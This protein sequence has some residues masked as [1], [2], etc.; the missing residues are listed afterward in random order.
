M[1][2]SSGVFDLRKIRMG[3]PYKVFCTTDTMHRVMHFIYEHTPVDYVMFSL[4]DSILV[5]R[6]EKQV[7]VQTKEASGVISSSLWNT[8]LDNELDPMLA[9]ELSEIYAWSIDFFGLQE[10]DGF[11]VFY[12]EHYV[13]SNY[14]GLG[15]I[16]GAVFYHATEEFYAMPFVQDSIESFYDQEGN[17][18]RK[19]FLKAPLRYS[20]ISSR[21]SH[22]RFHPI[23]KYRRPH[24]GVDYAAP[25][26]TPVLA[27]GD[28]KVVK[29]GYAK[30]NGN[31]LK[32]QHNSVYATAYL[33]LSRYGK[34]IQ[35]GSYVK[36]GD[37]IGYVGSTG[38]ST[39]PHLDF[40]F[41]KNGY[42]VDPLK[43]KAPPVKP[44]AEENRTVY[45][46]LLQITVDR[47]AGIPMP[48]SSGTVSSGGSPLAGTSY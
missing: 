8:M 47:L 42:P 22:S 33:H 40:R 16:H 3:N 24:L 1:L 25:I 18:L 37:V 28:G 32:I 12:E 17:S 9:F 41:Y 34:G 39:G 27:I 6:Q 36:Q 10:G 31:W 45:D 30:G 48:D 11:K 43:V 20:R 5:S 15:K 35:T 13:D 7:R 4:D 29:K 21:Y 38:L 46:S 14:I 2:A 44:V 23:L 19:A 26:G